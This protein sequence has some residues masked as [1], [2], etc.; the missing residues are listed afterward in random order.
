MIS[1]SIRR[2][3]GIAA[4]AWVVAAMVPL[5]LVPVAHGQ[6]QISEPAAELGD[7]TVT[8]SRIRRPAAEGPTPVIVITREDIDNQ[9]FGTIQDVFDSVVQNT[10]GTVAQTQTFGFTPAAS[11]PRLR[12]FASGF[13]LV[14]IDGRRPPVYPLGQGAEDTFVDFA[15]IPLSMVERIEILTDGA[16]AVYGADA[17][18]GV[19]NIITRQDF[20]GLDFNFRFADTADGGY[21]NRRVEM[22]GGAEMG[23]TS[24]MFTAEWYDQEILWATDRDWA[25]SDI[26]SGRSPAEIPR[27]AY[28]F[29]GASFVNFNNGDITQAPGCGTP[30][31]PIGGLGIPDQVND[32]FGIGNATWC[33]FD[34]SRFRTLFPSNDMVAVT[35]HVNHEISPDIEFFSKAHFSVRDTFWQLEPNFYGSTAI[36]TPGPSDEDAL[37]PSSVTNNGIILAGAPNNPLGAAAPGIFV[38][39]MLEMGPRTSNFETTTYGALAGVRGSIG[40]TGWEWEGA[41]AYNRQEVSSVEP[42]FIISAFEAELQA[43][44]DLFQP[45][46]QSVLDRF[47]FQSRTDGESSNRT[48]DLTV[49]GDLGLELR[50]GPLAVA[51]H[52]DWERQTF[53]DLRDPLVL[54]GDAFDGAT[55]AAG[56]RDHWGIGAEILFPVLPVWELGAALRFDEY[57]DASLVGSAVSPRLT[58]AWRPTDRLLVRA[59]WGESFRAPDL[60]DLFGGLTRGFQTVLDSPR[61]IALGGTPNDG[62]PTSPIECN[63]PIQAVQV[64]TQGNPGLDEEHG[65]NYNI[66]V[67]WEIMDDMNLSVDYYNIELEDLVN[68][69]DEQFILDSCA[70]QGRLCDQIIRDNNGQ[71]LGGSIQQ[72]PVN[73]SLQSTDGFDIKWDY[74]HDIPLGSLAYTIDATW[75]NSLE[76]QFDVSSA[77]TEN[78]RLAT[79]PELRTGFRVDWAYADHGVTLRGS[80]VDE[81]PG[82]QCSAPPGAAQCPGDSFSDSFWNWNGQYRYDIGRNGRITVGINN[83]FDEV[84]P[85]DPTAPSWPY[86]AGIG[87]NSTGFFYNFSG[88]EYYLLYQLSVL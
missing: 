17:V 29:G 50:G 12:G 42:N 77:V 81:I 9:G 59:S 5:A 46:P 16:S 85:I 55:E 38:R 25:D 84:P 61:C 22:V 86:V 88:R 70:F 43:G 8:G 67:V 20:Q 48:V 45:V 2:V 83:I 63:N 69:P 74:R 41:V 82:W 44:L 37:F 73:L 62:D 60:Q 1:D 10:S 71:L 13:T 56:A 18:A 30:A 65:Q 11:S 80:F 3:A 75:T 68:T 19:I 47:A 40:G 15:S 87:S 54:R 26:P 49:T 27:A 24:V 58:S 51:V 53:E 52:G 66:G 33:G 57:N 76:T 32:Q 31:D 6:E 64:N 28:S 23:R 7:I 4:P 35:G 39:R 21:G 78:L 36:F 79:L 72:V 14:L 34:R